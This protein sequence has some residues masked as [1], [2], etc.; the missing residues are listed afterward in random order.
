MAVPQRIE[1]RCVYLVH[2]LRALY[3][4]RQDGCWLVLV[5]A[6]GWLSQGFAQ[7]GAMAIAYAPT[8]LQED[9]DFLEKKLHRCHPDLDMYAS[10]ERIDRCFD[11]I[12]SYLTEPRTDLQLVSAAAALYPLLGDGHTMFL[13]GPL[14]ASRGGSAWYLPFEPVIV[15]GHLYIQR[16]GTMDD[17]LSAGAEVLAINSV[18]VAAIMD[19]L[20]WRQVRD[21]N[22]RTFP[23]WILDNWF[24]EY[25]RLSFG[26]PSSFAVDVAG[27]DGPLRV[28]VPALPKDSIRAN[29]RRNHPGA[30]DEEKPLLSIAPGGHHAVM[31]IAS[32]ERPQ[33]RSERERIGKEGLRNAFARLRELGIERLILDLR[34]N[35]G[36]E[37]ALAKLLLAH[38]LN[39]PFHLVWKGP[40]SGRCRPAAHPYT[41]KLIVLMDGGSF[42]ATGMVLSCLE[43]HGRAIFIGEE[44]GGNRTVLSGSPK[45]FRLPNTGLD[46]YISTRFWQLVD[47]PNDGHGVMPTIAASPTIENVIHGR[48]PVM[49]AALKAL[50]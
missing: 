41:G 17:R 28:T 10:H 30:H 5:F 7:S 37:P 42:S 27:A 46:C 26:E 21:G 31:T 14:T 23:E 40:A 43:R 48:D 15:G 4:V 34:G 12:R 18:P 8:A 29:I 35:Q 13:P 19:T 45:H 1:M 39:A 2:M 38:L 3:H 50:E 16:N 49:E 47:R 9:L 11:S 44:A 36:G 22:N 32:F 20:M 25:Y 6:I 33:D 24:K